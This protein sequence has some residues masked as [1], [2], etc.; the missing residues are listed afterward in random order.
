MS[1][2]LKLKTRHYR[3]LPIDKAGYA[4][5]VF[6]L[7]VERTALIG[8]HCWNV[9]L[10]DGPEIDVNYVTGMGWPQATE[11]SWRV[12]REVIRPA[13][14]IARRIGMPV[15]HVE[16]D[17]FDKHYPEVPSRR[18]P[19]N[20]RRTASLQTQ[21]DRWTI[22]RTGELQ[23][24]E[25]RSTGVDL[26]KSPAARMKR[27]KIVEPMGDEPL[28]F[29]TN[30][31]DAY[32]QER[33]VETLIYTGFA[34]DMC[35]LNSEGGGRPMLRAGY[36][37]IL[38]R[39]GTVGVE[40]PDTFPERLATRYGIHRFEIAVGYSTTWADFQAAVATIEK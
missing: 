37:C 21:S 33:G 17:D 9:G 2:T 38:M 3:A 30:Q 18:T 16:P 10:P 31:L 28:V 15:C 40:T 14:D 26:A 35:I 6:E 13:M 24:I 34:A 12:M 7:P 1:K 22:V 27:A 25:K 39:D 32:L 29:Y 8:L 11:E 36:R 23:T 5:D 4:E 19:E 20:Q